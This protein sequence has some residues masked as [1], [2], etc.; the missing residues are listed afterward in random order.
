MRAS[1]GRTRCC[2]RPR[3]PSTLRAN[4][5]TAHCMPR[6]MPKKGIP[7]GPREAD[8]LDLTLDAA[9]AEAARHQDAI[10]ARQDARRPPA[11]DLLRLDPAD[12]HPRPVGDPRV[13]E[14][15]V[16]RLVGVAVLHVLADDGDR[17]LG[18]GVEHP[19][20]HRPP[21]ADVERV[22]LQVQPLDQDLVEPVVDQAQRDLVDAEFL[23]AL[24]DDRLAL[25]V[26]EERD[27]V[28]VF[29]AERVLGPADQH[30]GLDADLP[31]GADGVLR[32]L[33]L[34]LAGGL[35]VGDERQV[36]VE[37]I[38]AAD[39][40]RE[41]ADRLQEREALDI[42]DR[43]AD[44]GDHDVHVVAGQAED[45]RLDLVGDVRDDLDGP[46]LVVP[47]LAFFVDD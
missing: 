27:L 44:L 15:L 6:Q 40:E 10:D 3:S 17:H 7:A 46:A 25:D 11:A 38:L 20:D 23:V 42:A 24:L 13:V 39:V 21:V 28:L 1:S 43:A 9:H 12:D 5:M 14:R 47:P 4:S 33:G 35:E 22:G 8:G 31:E 18:I 37:A 29:R 41:L 34:Q 2:W 32:R 26:A 16:H 36:D 45:G 19:V 30:V